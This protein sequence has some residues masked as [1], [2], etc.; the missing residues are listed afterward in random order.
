MV[1]AA[2]RIL[3]V[4]PTFAVGGQQ[5]RLASLISGLGKRYRHTILAMD[6]NREAAATLDPKFDCTIV[7]MPIEKT[8]GISFSNLRNARRMLRDI[9]PD[10]LCT[11]NWGSIEWTLANH[12]RQYPQLHFEDGFGP[13]ESPTRQRTRRVLM[14]RAFLSGNVRVVV[15][16][17]VL[18]KVAREKWGL[19]AANIIYLPNGIDT[20]RFATKPD[21]ELLDEFGVKPDDSIIGT[22]AAL[23]VEK[24]LGRLLRVVASL[25]VNLKAKLVIVGDGP[26]RKRLSEEAARLGIT[27]RVIM[28]GALAQPERMLGRFDVFALTSDTEQMPN[29]VLEAM[30]ASLPV[31]TTDVGDIRQ[32]LAEKNSPYVLPTDD[33]ALKVGLIDLLGD[34]ALRSEIGRANRTRVLDQ[35]GIEKMV[36]AYDQL[37]SGKGRN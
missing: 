8:S 37:L 7:T 18:Q 26:E 5:T 34:G 23:R 13:D 21:W 35:Y 29:S 14:R 9:K 1:D 4:F 28:T 17:R 15:P 11:Y 31:L 19:P 10:R 12:F 30:A 36:T 2:R 25:P 33:D 32:M 22:V 20:A 27:E 6:G 24:N 16:S 3:H